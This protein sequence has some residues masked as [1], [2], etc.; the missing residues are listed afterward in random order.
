GPIGAA[1]RRLRLDVGS[2][3]CAGRGD[4]RADRA[5]GADLADASR[6]VADQTMPGRPLRLVVL[7]Y[8]EEQGSPLVRNGGLRQPRQTAAPPGPP[9]DRRARSLSGPSAEP[10]GGRWTAGLTVSLH[11]GTFHGLLADSPDL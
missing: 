2:G 5:V 7:R 6:S 1:W 9:Q 11:R 4:P 10:H 3:A 8:H